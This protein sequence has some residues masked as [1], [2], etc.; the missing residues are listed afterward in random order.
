M[1]GAYAGAP[2]GERNGAYRTGKHTKQTKEL[3]RLLRQMA[4]AA[5]VL[6]ATVMSRAGLKVLK[7]LRRRRHVRRALAE[8][9]KAKPKEGTT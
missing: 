7:P 1:H 3:G 8:A 2:S 9:A 5:D 6:T 4:K